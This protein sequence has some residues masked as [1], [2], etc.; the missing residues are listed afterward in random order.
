MSSEQE[1]MSALQRGCIMTDKGAPYLTVIVNFFNMRREAKRT[2]Y[3]LTTNYQ[4]DARIHDYE[5]IAID[6][7]SSQPLDES[8]V[9]GL[10][11]NFKYLYYETK[12]SSPCVAI[13]NVIEMTRSPLIMCIIDGARILSPG[14]VNHSILASKLY[15]HPFIYTLAMHIGRKPQNLL[16]EDGYNQ[17][18]ED[19]LI[20]GVNWKADGYDLFKISVPA[21]AN[22]GGFLSQLWESNCYTLRRE[23]LLGLGLFDARFQTPG[24]GFV[25]PDHFNQVHQDSRFT[26]VML[27]GEATFHQFHGGI[28]S[29]VP[30]R[31]LPAQDM[32]REYRE[33]R[34]KIF[35]ASYRDPVYFGRLPAQCRPFLNCHSPTLPSTL[36]Q[37]VLQKSKQM[38]QRFISGVRPRFEW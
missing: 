7:G 22:K 14:I 33:I 25:G 13:N 4:L 38:A 28:T 6:N 36:Q 30:F 5:V 10:S 3:S 15:A 1:K 26:P 29:N 27:L 31:E 18:V 17:D 19:K 32:L 16:L 35:S 8:W 21:P 34:G 23:D 37:R 2:L 12:S 9:K 20:A 24:G 11:S